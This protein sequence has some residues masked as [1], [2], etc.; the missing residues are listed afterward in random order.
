MGLRPTFTLLYLYHHSCDCP[1]YF[2]RILAAGTHTE[3]RKLMAMSLIYTIICQI[4]SFWKYAKKIVF[5]K[6][7]KRFLRKNK[8]KVVTI[9]AGDRK[10]TAV[11]QDIGDDYVTVGNAVIPIS[12][13]SYLER[14]T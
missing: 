11:L 8:G 2:Q 4:A 6:N 5:A 10:F 1:H 13:I 14:S 3:Y 9:Q 7:L 12:S